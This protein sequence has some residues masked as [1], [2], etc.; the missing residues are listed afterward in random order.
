MVRTHFE[1][2]RNAFPDEAN[3]GMSLRDYF[4]AHAM[5]G[6]LASCMGWTDAEQE[7][8][9]RTSYMMADKMLIE[10]ESDE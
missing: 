10:R 8:M 2:G 9:A 5:Q 6:M 3:R 4:A 7:R 1:N